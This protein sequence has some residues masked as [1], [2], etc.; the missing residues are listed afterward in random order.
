MTNKDLVNTRALT[1]NTVWNLGSY[2]LPLLIAVF[3]I[4]VL[5]KHIGIDRFGILTLVWA[6]IGY[7]SLSD[8]G[9]GRALTKIVAEKLGAGHA[10]DI[11][12]IFWTAL[13]LIFFL[14]VIGALISALLSPWLVQDIIKIPKALQVEALQSFYLFAFVIP[15]VVS[16]AG[17]SGFLEAH[18]R[19]DLTGPVRILMGIFTFL[20]PLLVLPFSKSLLWIVTVLAMGRLIVWLIS[21]LFCLKVVPALRYGI[22]LKPKIIKPLFQFGAWM[23]IS[24]IIG[25]LMVYFDRFLIG[26][27]IS[28]AAAA[29][30]V[31][32]YEI[33]TRLWIIPAALVG[34]LFPAFSTL[35]NQ[36]IDRIAQLFVRGVKYIFLVLFPIVLFTITMA[37]EGLDLWLGNEFAER[38]THIL[39][40][41]SAGLLINSMAQVPFALVQGAG[42]PDLTAKLHFLECPFYLAAIWTLIKMYGIEGAAIAW[43]LRVMVDAALL[44]SMAKRL[45]LNKTLFTRNMIFV[46]VIALLTIVFGALLHDILIK[47][48]FV[49]VMFLVFSIASWFLVLSHD[50]RMTACKVLKP[51][52]LRNEN[53]AR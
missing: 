46:L 8:L 9:L 16:S 7:F 53:E 6:I 11:P 24:N 50:E 28:V 35:I 40:W 1:R 10:D 19:F 39:Q 17:L 15:I 37:H 21:F 41:L 23:T 2:V 29:Y 26:A 30:Y 33:V 13:F 25:P 31:T 48:I 27:T 34:V 43:T 44:F 20:G 5:I 52:I 38:S 22:A 3:T 12:H 18:Q 14:G 4:P 47:W 49:L 45:F 36:D 42:R 32:P 51:L